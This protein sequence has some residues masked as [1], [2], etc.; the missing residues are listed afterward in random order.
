MRVPRTLLEK[1]AALLP[2]KNTN[3]GEIEERSDTEE[4]KAVVTDNHKGPKEAREIAD[5]M[6]VGTDD[7]SALERSEVSKNSKSEPLQWN[8]QEDN[9]TTT[10]NEGNVTLYRPRKFKGLAG[11]RKNG[12]RPAPEQ[13]Q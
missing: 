4:E 8:V 5:S 1:C 11:S 13:K 3:A 12:W 10:T 2:C 9:G 7:R 6:P